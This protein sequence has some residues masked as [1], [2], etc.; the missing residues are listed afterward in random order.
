MVL[1]TD[2]GVSRPYG[3]NPYAY[4]DRS[5]HPFDFQVRTDP[6]LP[7]TE[8]ILGVAEGGRFVAFPLATLS[9]DSRGGWAAVSTTM[10]GIPV[11]VFWHTGTVAALD[12]PQIPESRGIG[13][14]AAYIPR[15][16]GRTLA[17]RAGAGGIVDRQ[18]GT[19]WT[20]EGRAVSG[21]LQGTQLQAARAIN[22][23][24]L[25]WAAF[26]PS[27]TIFGASR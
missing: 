11:A 13:A 21:P 3:Q 18:T 17:F 22:S 26:H 5:G 16:H 9:R 14:A 23:F 2:T 10:G 12:A 27:T 15:V 4:Y 8:Y 19:R 24:W 6:R 20:I 25:D 7:A 1:S